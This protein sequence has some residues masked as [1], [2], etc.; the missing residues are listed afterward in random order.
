MMS[1]DDARLKSPIPVEN[2]IPEKSTFGG[3]GRSSRLS[4]P[5][6]PD[7]PVIVSGDELISRSVTDPAIPV[8]MNGELAPVVVIVAVPVIL[9]GLPPENVR[10]KVAPFAELTSVAAAIKTARTGAVDFIVL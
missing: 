6:Y 4:A 7:K 2:A 3:P 8:T 9:A 1:G 10:M 5:S